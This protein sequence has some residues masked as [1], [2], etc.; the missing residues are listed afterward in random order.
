MRLEPD[1]MRSRL[2]FSGYPG[3]HLCGTRRIWQVKR[4]FLYLKLS[5]WSRAVLRYFVQRMKCTSSRPM[6][7]VLGNVIH[8]SAFKFRKY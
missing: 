8:E 6:D 3:R 1:T 4:N 2:Q 5:S 7:S